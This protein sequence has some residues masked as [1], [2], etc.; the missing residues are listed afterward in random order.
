[1]LNVVNLDNSKYKNGKVNE[2]NGKFEIRRR[3]C[4]K[5]NEYETNKNV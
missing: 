3:R 5:S 1:M 4:R 2:K